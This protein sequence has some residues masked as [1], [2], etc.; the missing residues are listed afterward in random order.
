MNRR[1]NVRV[2]L[3]LLAGLLAGCASI[4]ANLVRA[5]S[6]ELSDVQVVDLGFKSQTFLLSFE[7]VNPN[8]FS[9]PVSHVG[10]GVKLDGQRFA[11]GETVSEFTVPASGNARFVIRVD[12]NLLQT[13]PQLL[14]IVRAGARKD[15]PYQLEGQFSVNIP[16]TP[17]IR[18]R[19]SGTIQFSSSA[20]KASLFR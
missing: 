4:P 17:P 6:V 8:S 10:Y 3:L 13:A 2:C 15:I 16:L 9:L 7:V 18:Y 12:V 11:S 5:P 20:T 19:H 14:S 1:T